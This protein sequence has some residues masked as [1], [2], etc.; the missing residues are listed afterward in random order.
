L[1]TAKSRLGRRAEILAAGELGRRGYR[2]VGSNYHCRYGEIDLIAKDGETLVFVEVRSKT[3]TGHGLPS[4]TVDAVKQ[5]KLIMTARCYLTEK[6]LRDLSCRF[7]V[8]EVIFQ[9]EKPKIEVIQNAFT[10]ES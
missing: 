6:D 1:S 2:I 4:E 7:D 5:K 8:V 9:D 10:S 3:S